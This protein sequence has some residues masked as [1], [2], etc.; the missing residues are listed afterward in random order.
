MHQDSDL[1]HTLM[2]MILVEQRV[3]EVIFRKSTSDDFSKFVIAR[4]DPDG[5][6]Y[7]MNLFD[8]VE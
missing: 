4:Y 7:S 6:E 2:K 8:L 5:Y 1:S 3:E